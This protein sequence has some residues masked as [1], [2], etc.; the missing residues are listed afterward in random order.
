MSAQTILL[1]DDQLE[2]F[3]RAR[4]GGG[5]DVALLSNIVAAAETTGQRSGLWR[6][7]WRAALPRRRWLMGVL[8]TLLVG[9]MAGAIGLGAGLLRPS[10]PPPTPSAVPSI[11]RGLVQLGVKFSRPFE[12]AIPV[13]SDLTPA[14]SYSRIYRFAGTGHGVTVMAIR[15]DSVVHDCRTA[16]PGGRIPIYGTPAEVLDNLQVIGGMSF[17]PASPAT[18]DGRPGVSADMDPRGNKCG[19]AADIHVVNGLTGSNNSVEMNVYARLILA[20]FDGVVVGVMIWTA[21]AD[22]FDR[23]VATDMGLV[24]SMNFD[25][26]GT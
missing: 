21:D 7:L 26:G 18:L 20:D 3:L 24:N 4:S 12:Y 15:P 9:A 16:T 1:T 17:G 14:A 6:G 11:F 5:A 8:A 2:L 13:G 22:E 10:P 23:W 19:P 25:L